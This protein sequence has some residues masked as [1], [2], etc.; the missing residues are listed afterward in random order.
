[1]PRKGKSPSPRKKSPSKKSSRGPLGEYLHRLRSDRG[2]SLRET[3]ERVGTDKLS[4]SYLSQV[5][6]GRIKRPNPEIL[7]DL[8]TAYQADYAELLRRAGYSGIEVERGGRR[9]RA[10]SG[11]EWLPPE[12]SRLD[13]KEQEA[14]AQYIEFL[15]WRR[16]SPEP[17]EEWDPEGPWISWEEVREWTHELR[18]ILLRNEF[19][20]DLVI[21]L[22]RGGAILGGMVAGALGLKPVG[23]LDMVHQPGAPK[24]DREIQGRLNLK[25]VKKAVLVQGEVRTGRSMEE[26]IEKIEEEAVEAKTKVKLRKVA[27]VVYPEV[28]IDERPDWYKKLSRMDPPWRRVQGYE[29]TLRKKDDDA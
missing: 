18:A 7:S 22:G 5:E 6:T 20:P 28:P 2:L 19:D 3:V 24:E 4:R 11:F 16:Q 8:V 17:D 25:D 23:T 15:L 1:M 21:G 26:A 13:P 14:V 27:L 9:S 12:T 10:R 29:R